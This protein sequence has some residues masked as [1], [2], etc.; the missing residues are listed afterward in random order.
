M[1]RT[2][3]KVVQTVVYGAELLLSSACI[4]DSPYMRTYIPGVRIYP[5][6]EYPFAKLFAF[7]EKGYAIDFAVDIGEFVGGFQVWEATTTHA[8]PTKIASW[9]FRD[10][11]A[12]WDVLNTTNDIDGL[13]KHNMITDAPPGSLFCD[14]I[15][16]IKN[17][18]DT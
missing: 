15:T 16:L 1:E 17:I 11:P 14:D 3:F 18:R 12:F 8:V 2:V 6:Q 4:A 5:P 9:R 13:W 7:S 10:V